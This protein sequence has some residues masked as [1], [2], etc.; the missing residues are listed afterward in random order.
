MTATEGAETL[1]REGASPGAVVR[2]QHAL[3]VTLVIAGAVVGL[4]S[5]QGGYFPTS[6]GLSATL[7]LWVSGLWL[8][9]SGR[10]DAG[11]VDVVFLALLGGVTCWIGLSIAWSIVPAQSVLE[12]ERALVPLAGIAALLA[13]A[14]K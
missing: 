6:W 8:V 11:W 12:L 4:A 3:P 2:M 9:V 14:R 5:A 1:V 7:L 10:T 13:L